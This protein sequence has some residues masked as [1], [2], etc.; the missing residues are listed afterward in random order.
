MNYFSSIIELQ[1][2]KYFLNFDILNKKCNKS[3]Q[4]K[5]IIFQKTLK[6]DF[7]CDTT[8]VYH[9]YLKMVYNYVF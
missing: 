1:K 7:L 3:I 8:D 6:W 9:Y 4:T 5:T 2:E